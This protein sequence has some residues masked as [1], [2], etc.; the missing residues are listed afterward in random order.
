MIVEPLDIA[1]AFKITPK[2]L[3][4]DRG[5]FARVYCADV[6]AEHGLNTGW[7]QM[8]TSRTSPAGVVRGLH[9]QRPPFAEIKL[10]RC[11]QG[12]VFDVFVDL[13]PTS[14][15]FGQVAT[16]ELD[17]DTLDSVYIP[18]GCAH[19]FQTLTD[20]AELHYCHSQPYRPDFEDGVDLRDPDLA[21]P[22]PLPITH[23]S[24]RDTAHKPFKSVAPVLL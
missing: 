18:A 4:D 5:A 20:T 19:G 13:R 15:S 9:F 8:N 10:V 21:I 16:V 7:L 23:M 12:K 2:K 14:E 17:G 6:F 24:Q 3:G 11:V 22:W 1:G